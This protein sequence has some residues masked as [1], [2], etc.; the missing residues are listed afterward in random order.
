M[1]GAPLESPAVSD[2]IDMDSARGGVIDDLVEI[3]EGPLPTIGLARTATV[4]NTTDPN[5]P[6]LAE[7]LDGAE[8]GDMLVLGW[9][10]GH[11]SVFGGNAGMRSKAAGCVGLITNGYVRDIDELRATGL[12]VWAT[13][14][15]PRSGKGRLAVVA[16]G[17]PTKLGDQIV[18]DRD[19]V[20]ADRTGICV[21]A[22]ESRDAVFH[23]AAELVARDEQFRIALAEGLTF[24]ASRDHAKTM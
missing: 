15:S 19:T 10:A 1:S 4:V 16:V 8:P 23:H 20:I 6:G 11:A 18:Y 24:A 21:I 12:C 9:N 13:G 2:A 5:I 14:R 22:P 17:Q 7:Y 3:A